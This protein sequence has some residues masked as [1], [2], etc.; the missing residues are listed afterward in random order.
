[1]AQH[2]P[3]P[4]PSPSSELPPPPP[5]P[6]LPFHPPQPEVT[7]R[8]ALLLRR[9][10]VL[11]GARP[12]QE[13][14]G[15][16]TLGLLRRCASSE[17]DQEAVRT[18]TPLIS[19]GFLGLLHRDPSE[20]RELAQAIAC[21]VTVQPE[22]LLQLAGRM[23]PLVR[24]K[25]GA[26]IETLALHQAGRLPTAPSMPTYRRKLWVAVVA[27]AAAA[28]A[29]LMLLA[30]G[31]RRRLEARSATGPAEGWVQTGI[32]PSPPGADSGRTPRR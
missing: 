30:Y 19:L 17:D 16:T 14:D 20:R 25:S 15:E 2:P 7:T 29:G 8:F 22:R 11:H 28:T 26:A 31:A 23:A 6:R 24:V 5:P 27:I 12:L 18:F 13:M 10:T 9:L 1:M 21:R 4:A 3:G 32:R